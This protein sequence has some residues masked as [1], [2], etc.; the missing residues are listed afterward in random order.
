MVVGARSV[1]DHQTQSL[2]RHTFTRIR[3]AGNFVAGL[4]YGLAHQLTQKSALPDAQGA[5]GNDVR[6]GLHTLL[7]KLFL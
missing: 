2:T 6:K 7:L 5:E 1:C 3:A 4:E